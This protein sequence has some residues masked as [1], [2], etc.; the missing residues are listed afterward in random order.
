MD[1]RDRSHEVDHPGVKRL[2]AQ[3][4]HS[5]DIS[6]LDPCFARRSNELCHSLAVPAVVLD[7]KGALLSKRKQLIFD[8]AAMGSTQSSS[9][10]ARAGR[11]ERTEPLTR[12][13][14]LDDPI[15]IAI[16]AAGSLRVARAGSSCGAFVLRCTTGIASEAMT[17]LGGTSGCSAPGS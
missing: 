6:H 11:P 2:R 12:P 15:A 1:V 3:S 14:M 13:M 4:C 7:K 8:R 9:A 5:S 17:R 10:Q 16:G